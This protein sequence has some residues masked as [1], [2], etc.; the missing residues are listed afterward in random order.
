MKITDANLKDF[1]AW[2]LR[3]GRSEGT[4]DLYI[5]NLRRCRDTETLTSRLVE[6]ELA[7]LSRR[8][9]KAA[10]AAWAHF[11]KDGEL[12]ADLKEIRLPPA[13]RITP[14]IPLPTSDWRRVVK[15]IETCKIDEPT[16][17]LSLVIA[18]RGLRVGDALRIRHKDVSRSLV[19]GV[20]SF[21]G[22]GGKRYEFPIG[23]I[24]HQ[25][26]ALAKIKHWDH[27]RELVTKS[28]KRGTAERRMGRVFDRF[29][30]D[31]ELEDVHPHRMRRTYATRY[32]EAL[33]GDPRALL[34][35]KDHMQWAS[36]N[37]AALYADAVDAGELAEVGERMVADL[38][39]A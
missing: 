3:R 9:N 6:G 17:Q 12:A 25:L 13:R 33:K 18:R 5:K 15:H 34:K 36:I 32:L 11:T 4:A 23:S 14:K 38:V 10:L 7:P 30:D 16:R 8:T 31:L 27:A 39:D 20:L 28:A 35:L 24:R 37:T 29:A 1:R 19:S 22:K 21:A 26:E 2:L